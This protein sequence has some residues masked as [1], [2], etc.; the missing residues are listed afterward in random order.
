ARWLDARP[1]HGHAQ[2][3]E[4]E[5]GDLP[6]SLGR[7]LGDRLE[8]LAPVVEADVEDAVD[9]C[10]DPTKD[11][12]ATGPIDEVLAVAV[13]PSVGGGFV[14]VAAAGVVRLTAT[15]PRRACGGK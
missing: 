14:L 2:Q 8:G 15:R 4:A 3:V 1:V 5:L 13:D 10:V 12:N 6:R 11:P 7:E 9:A